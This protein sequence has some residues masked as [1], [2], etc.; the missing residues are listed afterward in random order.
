MNSNLYYEDL[1]SII[2]F[3]NI[4]GINDK[5]KNTFFL[6]G[7]HGMCFLSSLLCFN[8]YDMYGMIF[9]NIY[10]FL[11]IQSKYN[12]TFQ[13]KIC[14]SKYIKGIDKCHELVSYGAS[15]INAFV[16]CILSSVYLLSYPD[17]SNLETS[18]E[19]VYKFSMGYYIADCIYVLITS[20]T[21]N[22]SKSKQKTEYCKENSKNTKD[23]LEN[24][25]NHKD[26]EINIK[27][28]L[29]IQDCLFILHHLSV[30]YYQ[31]FALDQTHELAYTAR[32]YLSYMFLAEYAVLPLN[33]GW[34]LINTN[35]T[36]KRKFMITGIITVIVYFLSRVVNFTMIMYLVWLDGYLLYASIGIPII[37]LNYYWFYKIV[38]NVILHL[39]TF[40]TPKAHRA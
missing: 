40:K 23:G 5:N 2:S 15:F 27:M 21:S 12:P 38:Y 34:Y 19:S 28:Q 6:F 9:Y 30:I 10:L 37:L 33:Y 16:N 14:P 20:N 32:Y 39:C 3:D 11:F 35:Q 1:R 22:T 13:K 18:L 8:Y 26:S 36:K 31:L 29:T 25:D 7:I 17:V 4:N 24:K